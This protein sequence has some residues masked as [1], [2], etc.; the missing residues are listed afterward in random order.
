MPMVSNTGIN[1][2]VNTDA[3][4][5]INTSVNT[6]ADTGIGT[7]VELAVRPTGTENYRG[8]LA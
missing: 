5:G 3:D 2:S 8:N 6:D 1:T 4:T 7:G